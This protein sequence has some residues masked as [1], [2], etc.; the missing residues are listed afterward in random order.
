MARPSTIKGFVS[1]HLKIDKE[2]Y[3]Q[4]EKETIVLNTTKSNLCR[5]ILREYFKKKNK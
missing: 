2:L 5:Y 3:E 1:V 4:I